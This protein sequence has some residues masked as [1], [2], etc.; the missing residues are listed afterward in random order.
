MRFR[1]ARLLAWSFGT[2]LA[3]V[4]VLLVLAQ[5]VEITSWPMIWNA[6]TGA[7]GPRAE[8]ATVAE[9]L[10]AHEGYR[11][12][13][14]SADVPKARFLRL[15]STGDLL[16]SQPREG[17]V[18]LLGRDADRDG[19]PDRREVLIQGLD[20]PHGV[21]I[22]DGYVYIGESGK[23]GRAP[24]DTASGRITGAYTHV[25]TGMPEGGNHWSRTVR[26]GPDGWLYVH[27]GSSCNVC[28]EEHAW[29][30][31][32]LRARP[33]GSEL[34]IYASGLRNS[35]G[36]DWAPWSGELYATDNGRDMLGDDYPPCE[37]NRIEPG[38]FY[39]WPFVNGFNDLDPD[40]GKGHEELLQTA[41]APAHGF[42][43]HNAPLGI[44]FL[45]HQ[46][47]PSFARA[48]LVALHGSWNRSVADGYKVVILR[49][50]EAGHISESDFVTGFE[51]A[52]KVIGRPVD[53]AE[54][55]DGTLYLSD[56]YAG[57]IYR[58]V[59]G[60][61]ST[62]PVNKDTPAVVHTDSLGGIDAAELAA[63]GQR[64][65]E[66]MNRHACAG[67]HAPGTPIGAKLATLGERYTVETLTDYFITPTAPMPIFPLTPEDR[68]A[69]A[70]HLLAQGNVR[71]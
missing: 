65:T 36:F 17:Q 30:A 20:R 41:I 58:L 35:V 70:L 32:L 50:D 28:A 40:M 10:Q 6:I 53:L 13:V 7:P 43:A 68:R 64:A 69:L 49:W 34:S 54:A 63:A 45:R 1:P 59:R 2:V 31:T 71:G 19:H 5:G 15:T 52:G 42:R 62:T 38:G 18:M 55:P 67:C 44:T 27:V 48:A 66:L 57:A 46:Q 33:D 39:G 14:Y 26:I 12:E 4:A 61:G 37:L 21:E 60:S 11:I 47:G 56:D 51:R 3:L 25:I 16:V 24:F 29:R 9:R 8:S 22:A 23:V